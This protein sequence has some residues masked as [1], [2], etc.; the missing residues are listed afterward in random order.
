MATISPQ[1]I[2]DAVLFDLARKYLWWQPGEGRHA[3]ERVIAQVMDV[4]GYDD[5]RRLEGVV[6]PDRLADVMAAAEPGWLSPRS[7]EF[8]R[9]RLSRATGRMFADK[10]PRRETGSATCPTSSCSQARSQGG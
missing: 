4:G 8:W 6:G 9:G 10:P 5:I 2:V 1:P 7:W 3:A